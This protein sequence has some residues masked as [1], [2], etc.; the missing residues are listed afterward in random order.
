MQVEREFNISADCAAGYYSDS[1][2][3]TLC[4]KG[5]Y[6]PDPYQYDCVP[7]ENGLTTEGRGAVSINECLGESNV[8]DWSQSFSFI[9]LKLFL[10]FSVFKKNYWKSKYL[11]I[12][13]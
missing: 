2:K 13:L 7:C 1:T 11:R 5:E 8:F 6:Q 4:P 9:V 10:S 3:C 12:R